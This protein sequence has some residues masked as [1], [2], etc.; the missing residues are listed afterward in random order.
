[1]FYFLIQFT[2]S[3][4]SVWNT[5]GI[6]NSQLCRDML[7]PM[8]QECISESNEGKLDEE[9]D[10][11]L[12]GIDFQ[13][14]FSQE[15]SPTCIPS[16]FPE[17]NTFKPVEDKGVHL[18][19]GI[20]FQQSMSQEEA[21]TTIPST[22]PEENG[23][24]NVQEN[25]IDRD[26]E[27]SSPL[28]FSTQD[29]KESE[30]CET[31]DSVS[32]SVGENVNIQENVVI[33]DVFTENVNIDEGISLSGEHD[34]CA[35]PVIQP[36]AC[37]E[38]KGEEKQEQ[39]PVILPFDCMEEKSPVRFEDPMDTLEETPIT[40]IGDTYLT[41]EQFN[42]KYPKHEIDQ[43]VMEQEQIIETVPHVLNLDDFAVFLDE[44][45]KLGRV[46]GQDNIAVNNFLDELLEQ[47]KN[48]TVEKR[49]E[50]ISSPPAAAAASTTV[51][52]RDGMEVKVEITAEE[53][54]K[55]CL[56]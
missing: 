7:L 14:S 24:S 48:A 31:V 15:K 54:S 1:M 16:T 27:M 13:Q 50:N 38:K 47:E 49:M 21:P 2:I 6:S 37:S 23:F 39:L 29:E 34:M 51:A 33:P 32:N 44:Q 52:S 30:K 46:L 42:E 17:E 19:D 4:F 40:D 53:T 41:D 11:L 20:D 45:E 12:N 22:F 36:F 56:Y 8:T 28:L 5:F 35:I 25:E 10:E 3:Y 43:P 18:V 26:V 55:V 9:I